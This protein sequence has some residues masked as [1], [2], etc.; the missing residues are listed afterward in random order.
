MLADSSLPITIITGPV[1]SQAVVDRFF[2]RKGGENPFELRDE[3]GKIM[4]EK[5]GIVREGR[6]L[7][8][9]WQ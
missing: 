6:G 1:R 8:Q 9:A 2:E 5:V 3:L 7:N 4:W